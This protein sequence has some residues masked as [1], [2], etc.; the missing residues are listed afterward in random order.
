MLVGSSGNDTF[1]GGDGSD[2]IY[3]QGGDD[4]I[5]VSGKSGAFADLINGGSGID[6]VT[7]MYGGVNSLTGFSLST[8]N[9][10]VKLTDVNGGSISLTNVESLEVSATTYVPAPSGPINSGDG[11]LS[12]RFL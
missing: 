8:A 11:G 5:T 12:K 3:G 9:S 10:A 7:I 2:E 4:T 1:Q 6:L